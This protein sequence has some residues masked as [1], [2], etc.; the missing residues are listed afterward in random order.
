[1]AG[2]SGTPLAKKLG[3]TADSRLLLLK[4]PVE[5]DIK[6]LPE[7]VSAHRR[8]TSAPYD[9]ILLFAQDQATLDK[10]FGPAAKRLTTTGG[11]WICWPKKSSGV[12]TD[13]TDGVVRGTGL[14]AGLVDIKVCAVDDTWSALRFV[15]RLRDR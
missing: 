9:T 12:K 8:P 10:G 1:M 11:L 15:R 2:Y 6:D 4:A 5:F 3:V 13:L 14:A 7:G